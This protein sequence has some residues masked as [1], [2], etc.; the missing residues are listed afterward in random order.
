MGAHYIT[1]ILCMYNNG[2]PTVQLT[3]DLNMERKTFLFEL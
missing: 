1:Q 3:L 2:D